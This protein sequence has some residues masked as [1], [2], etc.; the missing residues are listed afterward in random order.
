[1]WIKICGITDVGTAREV[2]AAFPDAIG[3]NFYARSPRCVSVETAAEIVRALPA[4]IEPVGLFVNHTV[5]TIAEVCRSCR[6]SLV[7][8]HGDEPPSVLAELR[9][10]IP[11][12]RII[13]AFRMGSEGLAPLSE[14][15]D[16][17]EALGAI[18]YACLIDARVEGHY[19]GTGQT[20]PWSQIGPQSWCEDWP[21]LILAG[22]LEPSNIAEAIR[23]V[24]PWGVDTASGVESSPGQKD[25]TLVQGFVGNA[26]AAF[27]EID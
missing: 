4:Q 3:L 17:C 11:A 24:Q 25:R 18:L 19:G 26:K 6:F 20:A 12:V 15:L 13:R 22:G 9:E 7:Q 21:P 10:A 16:D 27:G 8:L 23:S 5:A 2:A 14:Y 1:M